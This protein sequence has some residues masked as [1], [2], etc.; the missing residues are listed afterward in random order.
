MYG[1]PFVFP[2]S[3]AAAVQCYIN[4]AEARQLQPGPH[5]T[6]TGVAAVVVAGTTR[7]SLGIGGEQ[8]V[9]GEAD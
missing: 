2:E 1:S 7:R 4:A 8:T 9:G 3:T 6:S 5:R